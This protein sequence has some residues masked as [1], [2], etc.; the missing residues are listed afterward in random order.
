MSLADALGPHL[1]ESVPFDDAYPVGDAEQPALI[2][3]DEE[4]DDLFDE[5]AVVDQP[6]RYSISPPHSILH[7][8]H[9]GL[10]GNSL[11]E[12]RP[13]QTAGQQMRFLMRNSVIGRL[14]NMRRRRRNQIRTTTTLC[15]NSGQK[16][17]HCS[18]MSLP[19]EVQMIRCAP[20]PIVLSGFRLHFPE[21]GH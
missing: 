19:R 17:R 9:R 15:W 1:S 8:I 12:T 18:R 16:H 3:Q 10:R 7:Q 2:D 13:Y 5:N 4:M 11:T 20:L 6:E 14:W 21:L